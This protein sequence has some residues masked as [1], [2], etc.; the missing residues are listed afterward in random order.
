[1][2]LICSEEKLQNKIGLLLKFTFKGESILAFTM[3][4]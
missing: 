4:L 1:M 3:I 2:K